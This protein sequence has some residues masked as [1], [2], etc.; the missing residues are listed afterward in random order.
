MICSNT[1]RRTSIFLLKWLPVVTGGHVGVES[2]AHSLY[3]QVC[4][5]WLPQE[6]LPRALL[7]QLTDRDPHESDDG[8]DHEIVFLC[9]RL[10]HCN[11]PFCVCVCVC[12][13]WALPHEFFFFFFFLSVADRGKCFLIIKRCVLFPFQ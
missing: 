11:L 9:H 1:V 2:T 4:Y 7:P 10:I 5:L 6:A 3:G 8:K 12:R 13:S